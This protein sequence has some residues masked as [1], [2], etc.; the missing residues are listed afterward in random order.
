MKTGTLSNSRSSSVTVQL[1]S[2]SG[3]VILFIA[4]VFGI[5]NNITSVIV[6]LSIFFTAICIAK[7]WSRYSLSKVSYDRLLGENRTFPG[8]TVQLTIKVSN[9]KLLPLAWLD[10]NDNLPA[11]LSIVN[12]ENNRLLESSLET[13]I[14]LSGYR[15]AVW[16]YQVKC[17]KRG[18]YTFGPASLH[19]GDIFGFYPRNTIWPE[20]DHLIVY[21]RIFPIT[22]FIPQPRQPLGDLK[23]SYRIFHDPTR[24]IG[25]RE[26]NPGDP[27][28]HIHWKATARH[29]QLQVKEFE[30]STT[31]Q[32]IIWLAIDSFAY[33]DGQDSNDYFEW[34]ISTVA[35]I[36]CYLTENDFPLGLFANTCLFQEGSY[37]K[38]LPG[39]S[40][41]HMVKMLEVLA[42]ITLKPFTP[43]EDMISEQKV[44]LPWGSTLI[45]VAS[46][47]SEKLSAALE[48]LK[49]SR[50]QV[51]LLKIGDTPIQANHHS[52]PI[53]RINTVGDIT[54]PEASLALEKVL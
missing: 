2:N 4:L 7:L 15:R 27:F 43:L 54:K 35:S 34:A 26:Y 30:P 42:K 13:S 3:L 10:I 14:T 41:N 37:I 47:V 21:P 25:I 17:H 19:S 51:I 20:T 16:Q 32:T 23:A 9:N 11:Q 24:P 22:N 8:E 53:Y 18:Y 50:H 46:K 40:L 39:T 28:N 31:L 38:T 33:T 29:Q 5:W 44:S 12:I 1:V 36:A 6:L 48:D 52:Y 49:M 45:F